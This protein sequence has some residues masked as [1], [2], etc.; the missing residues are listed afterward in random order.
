M[1]AP[2]SSS[3]RLDCA[4]SF[5]GT[6]DFMNLPRPTATPVHTTC[7]RAN[8]TSKAE[9]RQHRHAGSEKG[10]AR[11][12]LARS[13]A[14]RYPNTP[15]SENPLRLQSVA[16]HTGAGSS[17]R[18]LLAFEPASESTATRLNRVLFM[19]GSSI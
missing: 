15:W 9:T 14:D 11:N 3:E 2:S 10:H 18:Y 6:G 17:Q 4:A 19:V 16:V 5:S 1:I 13:R 7:V 8:Q 12:K